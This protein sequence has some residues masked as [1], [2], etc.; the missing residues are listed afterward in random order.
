MR[1]GA[2]TS[3]WFQ[4]CEWQFMQVSEDG[5]PAN[6]DVATVVWQYSQAMPSSP[7]WCLWLNGI[8]C[9]IGTPAWVTYGDRTKKNATPNS[10]TGAMTAKTRLTRATALALCGKTWAID[11]AAPQA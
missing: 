4:T 11:V 9:S 10:A 8:G 6:D 1:T 3:L 7:T 5:I 2:S